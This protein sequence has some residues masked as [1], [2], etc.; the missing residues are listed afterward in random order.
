[1]S[2]S[3]IDVQQWEVLSTQEGLSDDQAVQELSR[4]V[5]TS[6]DSLDLDVAEAE[7]AFAGAVRSVRPLQQNQY[8]ITWEHGYLVLAR[9]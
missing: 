9:P 3:Q 2:L 7:V 5:H 1:M 6:S 4:H 8:L